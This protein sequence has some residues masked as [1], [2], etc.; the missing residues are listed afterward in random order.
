M[1]ESKEDK[2][3]SNCNKRKSF[4]KFDSCKRSLT[5]KRSRCKECRKQYYLD[6]KERLLKKAENYRRTLDK[7]K[8]AEYN[9]RYRE[10]NKE[11]ISENKKKW[12][13]DN[14]VHTREW[15][16]SYTINRKKSD[17][18]FKI[19]IIVSTAVYN[20]IKRATNGG[21]TKGGSTFERLSYTPQQLVEHLEK[22]FLEGMTWDNWGHGAGCWHIDHIVPQAALP[23]DSLEHPNFQKCWTIEN[24]RPLWAFENLS[25]GSLH[26][27]KR[28][29][30][31]NEKE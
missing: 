5:G 13:E 20:T 16:R 25:K 14:R 19:K 12:V 28:Y 3:C 27:G 21:G 1:S 26:E 6:N 2:K 11:R 10:E 31:K 24:L 8:V 29:R 4:D 17:L 9:K 30:Y 22:Q 15:F 7:E 18:C 23:Y